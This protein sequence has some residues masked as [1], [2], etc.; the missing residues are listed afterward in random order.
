MRLVLWQLLGGGIAG[1][2]A[3]WL[4]P[5]WPAMVAAGMLLAGVLHLDRVGKTTPAVIA[6]RVGARGTVVRGAAVQGVVLG[7]VYGAAAS[8]APA[9]W[10]GGASVPAGA[11]AL[12]VVGGI[13]ALVTGLIALDI[14]R[15]WHCREEG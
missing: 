5:F 14:A 2:A 10:V 15:H 11:I 3:V 9:S 8:M 12:T 1:V 6:D 7:A 13:T 4:T